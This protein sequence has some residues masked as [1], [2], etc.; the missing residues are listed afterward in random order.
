MKQLSHHFDIMR[1]D[2]LENNLFDPR[3][4]TGLQELFSNTNAAII[5]QFH[6]YNTVEKKKNPFAEYSKEMIQW[7]KANKHVE[8]KKEWRRYTEKFM[9]MKQYGLEIDFE[10]IFRPIAFGFFKR[11]LQVTHCVSG[12]AKT[13]KEKPLTKDIKWHWITCSPMISLPAWLKR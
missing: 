10:L 12:G 6:Y 1:E 7:S 4:I 11:K 13:A 8:L 9:L 3:Q 2:L 5:E